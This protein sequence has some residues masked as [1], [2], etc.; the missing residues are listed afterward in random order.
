MATLMDL[1]PNDLFVW[2]QQP[3]EIHKVVVQPDDS[4]GKSLCRCVAWKNEDTWVFATRAQ[5]QEWNPLADIQ[6]ISVN[7]QPIE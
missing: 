6:K 5:D 1:E 3:N 7:I 4:S 2:P